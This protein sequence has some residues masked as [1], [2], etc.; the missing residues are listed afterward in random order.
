MKKSSL[1]AAQAALGLL[2][3]LVL[4]SLNNGEMTPEMNTFYQQLD[5]AEQ[6]QFQELDTEHKNR[7]MGIVEKFCKAVQECKGH[8]EES[9]REQYRLQMQQKE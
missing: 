8:R 1:F 2:M 4:S 5:P 6:Q 7:A 9:V 3:G